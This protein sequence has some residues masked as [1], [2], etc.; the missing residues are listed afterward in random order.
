MEPIRSHATSNF[1]AIPKRNKPVKSYEGFARPT[2]KTFD[3]L[4]KKEAEDKK[5]QELFFEYLCKIDT[6]TS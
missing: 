3:R 6:Q 5:A 1:I 4:I 2:D